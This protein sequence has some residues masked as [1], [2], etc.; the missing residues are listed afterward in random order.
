M[1]GMKIEGIDVLSHEEQRLLQGGQW[2]N[3]DGEWYWLD[4]IEPQETP[5]FSYTK[6]ETRE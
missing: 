1:K 6:K 2:V 4:V 5:D 3:V